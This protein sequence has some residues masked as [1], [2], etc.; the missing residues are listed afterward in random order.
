MASWPAVAR[1]YG[2]LIQPASAATS[3]TWRAS[4]PAP[5][6]LLRRGSPL[7]GLLQEVAVED[8]HG[9]NFPAG[10]EAADHHEILSP[11]WPFTAISIMH[12]NPFRGWVRLRDLFDRFL[13]G[14][15]ECQEL[16][17][18]TLGQ[19]TDTVDRLLG[20]QFAPGGS[21]AA[22][23]RRRG[24]RRLGVDL[25]LFVAVF[26]DLRRRAPWPVATEP[27]HHDLGPRLESSSSRGRPG[28]A[29]R[30]RAT[31]RGSSLGPAEQ[32][33]AV[34]RG[35]DQASPSWYP[36]PDARL[37][38]PLLE[39]AVGVP[40]FSLGPRQEQRPVGSSEPDDA[41]SCRRPVRRQSTRGLG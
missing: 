15:R 23:P 11:F 16:Y 3:S 2:R 6:G 31:G 14:T 24:G 34:R 7:D 5:A 22:R 36:R 40:P 39:H 38:E 19:V 26:L 35:D 4:A 13:G 9:G 8:A 20:L 30:S 21:R 41:R 17:E 32:E 28:Q 33:P 29:S 37:R 10:A 12:I 27:F 18:F 1:P 25:V